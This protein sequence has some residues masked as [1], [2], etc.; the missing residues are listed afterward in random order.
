MH[1]RYNYI[2]A[3]IY[4]LNQW[5]KYTLAMEEMEVWEAFKEQCSVK[6]YLVNACALLSLNY[7]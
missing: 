5:F 1:I 2:F 6:G 4:I 7:T 3:K